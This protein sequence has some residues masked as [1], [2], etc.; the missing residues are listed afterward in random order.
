MLDANVTVIG[1]F[2]KSQ[3]SNDPLEYAEIFDRF[4][5][6]DVFRFSKFSMDCQFSEVKLFSQLQSNVI[7]DGRSGATKRDVR[8]L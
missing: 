2:G 8:N 1:L 3:D 4:L 7:K 6:K 5:H